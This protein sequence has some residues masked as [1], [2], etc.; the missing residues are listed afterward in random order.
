MFAAKGLGLHGERYIKMS[1]HVN[2]IVDKKCGEEKLPRDA[3]ATSAEK[4]AIV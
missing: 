3:A 1:S 4:Q 2:L